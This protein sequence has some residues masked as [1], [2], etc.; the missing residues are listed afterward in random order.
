MHSW[1]FA[2]QLTSTPRSLAL[3]FGDSI[4]FANADSARVSWLSSYNIQRSTVVEAGLVSH[5]KMQY[6]ET[7]RARLWYRRTGVTFSRSDLRVSLVICHRASLSSWKMLKRY[8]HGSSRRHANLVFHYELHSALYHFIDSWHWKRGSCFSICPSPTKSGPHYSR[9][10]FTF[11][12]PS[13]RM[14]QQQTRFNPFSFA[15]FI[16]V[17]SAS[18][19]G[20]QHTSLPFN[21]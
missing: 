7:V 3:K 11:S 14:L 13:L 8:L 20:T 10:S 9:T 19:Y 21:I 2:L 4:K 6:K 12:H 15:P 17:L 18:T 5:E 16:W 1:L